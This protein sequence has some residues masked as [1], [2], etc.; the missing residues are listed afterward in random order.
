MYGPM[1][2]APKKLPWRERKPEPVSDAILMKEFDIAIGQEGAPEF[3]LV[4]FRPSKNPPPHGFPVVV[5]LN[6]EGN[7]SVLNNVAIEL[8]SAW[9]P[10]KPGVVNHRA[11]EA[12]R[13]S[14]ADRWQVEHIIERGYALATFYYGDVAPDKPGWEQGVFPYLSK[15]GK[16]DGMPSDWGAIA[17]W[18]WGLQR[19]V[20]FLTAHVKETSIDPARIIVFG[21]SRNG[22]AAMLAGAFDD[23]IAAVIA[24][25][26]GC[27]G[28]APSRRKNLHGEPVEKINHNFP[29]WF[30]AEFK[31]FVGHEDQ[32]PFD[33]NC[34]IALC[35]PRPVLLTCGEQDQWADPPG[36]LEALKSADSVYRLFG[37]EGIAAD[38]KAEDGKRIGGL[39]NYYIREAPHTVDRAYWDAFLDFCDAKVPAKK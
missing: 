18:A 26:A 39:L 11:T 6:F 33:Q 14:Q 28:T 38:A 25:Q 37:V 1:P 7:H 20:D 24:H 4:V 22:K 27:G 30:N 12:S 29:H 2:A 15:Q 17:A 16:L 21:H 5:G 32:L 31:K 35:A 13:G 10:D 3:H 23:R 19:A 36:E 9:M 8:P 34:L